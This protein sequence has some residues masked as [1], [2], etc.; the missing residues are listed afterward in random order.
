MEKRKVD[1]DHRK[2][3]QHKKMESQRVAMRTETNKVRLVKRE[4]IQKERQLEK[5]L[6]KNA[7]YKRQVKQRER[8][9]EDKNKEK[10]KKKNI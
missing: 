4:V 7:V 1:R 3:L 8:S 5:E 2:T 9:L 6:R 10:I